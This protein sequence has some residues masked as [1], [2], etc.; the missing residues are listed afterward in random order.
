MLEC[1]GI[2][3]TKQSFS[4]CNEMKIVSEVLIKNNDE[5]SMTLLINRS[6]RADTKI[7]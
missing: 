7:A 6:I 1:V 3:I 2:C 5:K 4:V